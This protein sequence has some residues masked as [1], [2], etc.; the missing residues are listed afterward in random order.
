M[1]Q[2]IN[3]T[4]NRQRFSETSPI[5]P[6]LI[7]ASPTIQQSHLAEFTRFLD[8]SRFVCLT[9][10]KGFRSKPSL[11]ADL[12]K[13]VEK[14]VA[15]GFHVIISMTYEEASHVS[16]R[17]TVEQETDDQSK[18]DYKDKLRRST[19]LK[20]EW[21][22]DVL[23]MDEVHVLR[24]RE[25]DRCKAIQRL[26]RKGLTVIGATATGLW[27]SPEDI[28]GE[29][30]AMC[31]GKVVS[32]LDQEL[33][34]TGNPFAWIDGV[35]TVWDEIRKLRAQTERNVSRRKEKQSIRHSD[36]AKGQIAAQAEILAKQA[37]WLG[38]IEDE[39]SAQGKDLDQ[40]RIRNS[41]REKLKNGVARPIL[42]HLQSYILR[43]LKSS[44]DLF[45]D[46]IVEMPPFEERKLILELNR[47]EQ[48]AYDHWSNK[49]SQT[50]NPKAQNFQILARKYNLDPH[51]ATTGWYNPTIAPSR[52]MRRIIKT[53]R[54]W[55]EENLD[56]VEQKTKK[57]VNDQT[58]LVIHTLWTSQIQVLQARL[59]KAG[60]FCK[61]LSGDTPQALRQGIISDFQR[62]ED[63][64]SDPVAYYDADNKLLLFESRPCRILII[65]SVGSSGITLHRANRMI[66][67]D[68][69]FTHQEY[70][71]A[72]GRIVRKGQTRPCIIYIITV[73]GTCDDWMSNVAGSKGMAASTLFGRGGHTARLYE[74]GADIL[75][76]QEV[77]ETPADA[78][79]AMNRIAIKVEKNAKKNREKDAEKG[80]VT[81][82][83][84]SPKVESGKGEGSGK[85]ERDEEEEDKG[86]AAK[87]PRDDLTQAT[88]GDLM[89]RD[90]QD[91]AQDMESQST[92]L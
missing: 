28:I 58:K 38:P 25:S 8:T 22:F 31:H 45:G 37:E 11:H 32:S 81:K 68:Q 14:K 7:L 88:P 70:I 89:D 17:V 86:A 79:E 83:P 12:V 20:N 51:F 16:S 67:V 47:N 74:E 30:A 9:F 52:K 91:D 29:A 84:V 63:H 82:K 4:R 2:Y 39:G 60:F 73:E 85:R 48:T 18:A 15:A 64:M 41:F 75:P 35:S 5:T 92:Q 71:Q 6:S 49:L 1:K 33:A 59:A 69:F 55:D 19:I 78:L 36:S 21:L 62:D 23:I 44:K 66:M 27:N 61:V 43:R 76:G 77:L 34:T 26:S 13:L 54:E 42:F 3:S 57:G 53:C 80:L 56:D 72:M 65:T 46:S 50:K 24:N 10:P 40:L 87:K 90:R